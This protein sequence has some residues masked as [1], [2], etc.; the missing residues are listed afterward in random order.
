MCFFLPSPLIILESL[1]MG[2]FRQHCSQRRSDIPVL[3]ASLQTRPLLVGT[4][5]TIGC[6]ALAGCFF[7][8]QHEVCHFT[9]PAIELKNRVEEFQD[10]LCLE[11][12]HKT[13]IDDDFQIR[14]NVAKQKGQQM[15]QCVADSFTKIGRNVRCRACR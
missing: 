8:P 12:A 1:L 9:H 4:V 13:T 15:V 14:G 7:A 3:R 6:F 10:G 2:R 11:K 5:A